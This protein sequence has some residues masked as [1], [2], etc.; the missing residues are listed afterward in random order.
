MNLPSS[1]AADFPAPR[2][3]PNARH[4]FGGIWRLT[5]RRLFAPMHWLVLAGLLAALALVT[6]GF[7]SGF[8]GPERYVVWLHRFYVLFLVPVMAFISGA[9][10]IRDDL[11]AGA[12]DYL[13][14]RPVSRRAY[15]VARYLSHMACAQV[16]FLMAFVLMVGLGLYRHSPDLPAAVPM[17]LLAQVITIVAFSAFGVLCGILTSRYVIIG[18]FYAGIIEVGIGNIPTELN[19]LSMTQQ[20]HA[21]LVPVIYAPGAALGEPAA[22]VLATVAIMVAFAA[23]MIALAATLF[24]V[25]EFSGMSSGES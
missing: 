10:A 18:M 24:T 22:G 6:L 11:K 3:A 23:V 13:F 15:V 20:V 14:T 12:V 5:L 7:L 8:R 1:C 21:M 25:R 9:G 4:A 16:D 2:V 19:R 17:L